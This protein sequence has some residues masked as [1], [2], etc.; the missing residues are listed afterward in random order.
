MDDCHKKNAS[1][2]IIDIIIRWDLQELNSSLCQ[3][4]MRWD[5]E[6]FLQSLGQLWII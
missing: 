5:R 1:L 2:K 3:I 4:R 6:M